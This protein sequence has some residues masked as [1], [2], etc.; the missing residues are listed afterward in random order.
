MRIPSRQPARLPRVAWAAIVP[1][2]TVAS[3]C[4]ITEHVE[5]KSAMVSDLQAWSAKH[6]PDADFVRDQSSCDLIPIP[7]PGGWATAPCTLAVRSRGAS[8]VTR[9]HVWAGSSSGGYLL[10]HVYDPDFDPTSNQAWEQLAK[11]GQG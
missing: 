11:S 7:D 3:A 1:M 5:D 9:V 6:Y 10:F 4:G 8:T 2:I